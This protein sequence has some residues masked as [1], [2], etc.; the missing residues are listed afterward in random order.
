ME[1]MTDTKQSASPPLPAPTGS[2]LRVMNGAAMRDHLKLIEETR[3]RDCSREMPDADTTVLIACPDENEPVWMGYW[4]GLAWWS[5][6]GG[7][8]K[9]SHWKHLPEPPNAGTQQRRDNP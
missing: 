5:V 1:N 9:V 4:D 3:W 8:V 6:E 7:T 2:G